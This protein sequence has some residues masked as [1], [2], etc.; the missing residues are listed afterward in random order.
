[1]LYGV[2]KGVVLLQSP[3]ALRPPG[4]K[5]VFA[6]HSIMSALDY[7]MEPSFECHY[8]YSSD[9]AFIRAVGSIGG[10]YAIEE[11]FACGMYPLSASFGFDGIA[12]SE[13]PVLKGSATISS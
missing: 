12:D 11:Y 3:V 10:R 1:M 7:T 6:L 9:V 4:G 8:T 2:D 13:S 5:G